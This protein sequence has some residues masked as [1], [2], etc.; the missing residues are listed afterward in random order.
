MSTCRVETHTSCLMDNHAHLLVHTPQGNLRCAMRQLS[1]VWQ[2]RGE[3]PRSEGF[4]I[5]YRSL[6]SVEL[7]GSELL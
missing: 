1:K 5:S 3:W 4:S 2:G 6:L 7:R